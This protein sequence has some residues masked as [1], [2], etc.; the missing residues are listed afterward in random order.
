[1]AKGSKKRQRAA[2]EDIADVQEH[3]ETSP[4]VKKSKLDSTGKAE[5]KKKEKKEKTSAKQNRPNDRLLCS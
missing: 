4:A 3:E 5:A 1:M 2:D